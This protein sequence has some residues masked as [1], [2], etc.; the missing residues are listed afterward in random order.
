MSKFPE[1]KA[2]QCALVPAI[3]RMAGNSPLTCFPIRQPFP[4]KSICS[5]NVFT[6]HSRPLEGRST[7]QTRR[8]RNLQSRA[9]SVLCFKLSDWMFLHTKLL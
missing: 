2:A 5:D 6:V 4:L 8:F 3:E 7:D 9:S 1:L